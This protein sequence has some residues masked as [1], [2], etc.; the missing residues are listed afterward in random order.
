MSKCGEILYSG[1]NKIVKVI[2][3]VD[4]LL[5]GANHDARRKRKYS[6]TSKI[7]KLQKLIAKRRIPKDVL[8]I[9]V[10]PDKCTGCSECNICSYNA[11]IMEND[12]PRIILDLCPR[13]GV[14]ETKCPTG[15]ITIRIAA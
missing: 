9:T 1:Y 14:C 7:Q 6:P 15:A 10:H 4:N 12:I 11:M 2:R 5:V 8:S 3:K 13:C